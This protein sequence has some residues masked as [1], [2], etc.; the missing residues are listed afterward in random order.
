ML[1]FAYIAQYLVG[2]SVGH[3]NLLRRDPFCNAVAGN[4][5]NSDASYDCCSDANT[6]MQCAL[7]ALN[8]GVGTWGSVQCANGC[9]VV[10]PGDYSCCANSTDNSSGCLGE[11]GIP[12]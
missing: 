6:L 7:V 4:G 10:S 9:I 11:V 5:C 8:N 1:A 3:P 2:Y 12:H